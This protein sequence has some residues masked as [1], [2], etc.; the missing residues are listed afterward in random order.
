MRS[1]PGGDSMSKFS[2]GLNWKNGSRYHAQLHSR[3]RCCC[4]LE[5]MAKR[6]DFGLI[7]EL[8]SIIKGDSS[9]TCKTAK[10]S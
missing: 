3:D 9:G 2:E 6:Y 7:D 1:K 5:G 8:W 10:L 4:S